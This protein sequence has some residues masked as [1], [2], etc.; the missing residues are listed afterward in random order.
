MASS[1]K[2]QSEP[3][4]RN[5]YAL[6]DVDGWT[7]H[8]ANLADDSKEACSIKLDRPVGLA[9]R[10]ETVRNLINF[11]T[12]PP[13]VFSNFERILT[14]RQ[15]YQASPVSYLNALGDSWTLWGESNSLEWDGANFIKPQ[16]GGTLEFWFLAP[17]VGSLGIVTLE[18]DIGVD[19]KS[20][21]GTFDIFS[22]ATTN[23]AQYT[24]T[25]FR[26]NTIDIAVRPTDSY[27]VL[28]TAE[29]GPGIDYFVFKSVSY[30]TLI[31]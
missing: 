8:A 26:T 29:I 16:R 15:P 10:L 4:D 5:K 14:P 21:S 9:K 24:V 22:D 1:L 2:S 25:G 27:A 18:V 12:L 17:E 19:P 7:Y 13:V 6:R 30:T 31:T 28:V 23:K 3:N 11:P 20:S